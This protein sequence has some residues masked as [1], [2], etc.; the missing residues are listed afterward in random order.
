[1]SKDVYNDLLDELEYYID[2][3]HFNEKK[4]RSKMLFAYENNQIDHNQYL[5]LISLMELV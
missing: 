4:F 5:H 3:G 2:V 1:M